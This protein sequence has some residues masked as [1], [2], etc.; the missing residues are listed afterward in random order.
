MGMHKAMTVGLALL[1]AGPA[2]SQPEG[3]GITNGVYAG[4][5]GSYSFSGNHVTGRLPRPR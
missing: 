3:D 2:L 1:W 5:R 4:L